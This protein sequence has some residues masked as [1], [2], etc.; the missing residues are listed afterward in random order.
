VIEV[1]YV[2]LAVPAF[3][4]SDIPRSGIDD[5]GT[6]RPAPVY[7]QLQFVVVDQALKIITF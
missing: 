7:E 2:L 1:I 5:P 4:V 3:G 6:K